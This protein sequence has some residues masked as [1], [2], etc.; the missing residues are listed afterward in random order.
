M[1]VRFDVVRLDEGSRES[2]LQL[3]DFVP[4]Q[5]INARTRRALQLDSDLVLLKSL[6]RSID[7]ELTGTMEQVLQARRLQQRRICIECR[8]VERSERRRYCTDPVV[9]TGPQ[10]FHQPWQRAR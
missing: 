9:R 8:H 7:E 10:E 6:L 2:G 5:D 4:A 1:P 3:V